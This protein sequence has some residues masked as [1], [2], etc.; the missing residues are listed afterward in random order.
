MNPELVQEWEDFFLYKNNTT[1]LYDIFTWSTNLWY[2]YIDIKWNKID[3]INNYKSYYYSRKI[4]LWKKWTWAMI[5]INTYNIE[6]KEITDGSELGS[7]EDNLE[8]S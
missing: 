6:I 8:F 4:N 5:W 1:K 7:Y 2:K 3:D